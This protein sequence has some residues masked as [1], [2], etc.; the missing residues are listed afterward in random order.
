MKKLILTLA[1]ACATTL[2]VARTITVT[3]TEDTFPVAAPGSLRE[4]LALATD[5]DTITFDDSLKGQTINIVGVNTAKAD[6]SLVIDKAITID[7]NGVIIDGGWNGVAKSDAGGRIF[8]VSS[9]LGKV[10]FKDITLQN[11]HGR[12]WNCAGNQYFDGGAVYALSPVRFENCSLIHNASADETAYAPSG[13]GARGGGAISA[14]NDVEIVSC[15]FGTN[16]IPTGSSSYGG[17]IR[18]V[19]GT[20][21]VTDTVF[22]HDYSSTFGGGVAYI[23][24][25]VTGATFRNCK[26]IEN[27]STMQNGVAGGAIYAEMASNAA[28][29]LFDCVF[30]GGSG[31]NQ[32]GAICCRNNVAL[33][34]VN[35]EFADSYT[36]FGGAIYANTTK[37]L[38][39]LN[40]TFLGNAAATW[41][42][43][44]EITDRA[45]CLV[46]CTIAGSYCAG[47]NGGGL[48]ASRGLHLLNT[49]F[50]YNYWG[51]SMDFNDG[52]QN[53]NTCLRSLYK[54]KST[55]PFG[56]N[57]TLATSL[58][59]VPSVTKL[60]ANYQ[61]VSDMHGAGATGAR[62]Q[63]P[64]SV[65]MPMFA[66]DPKSVYSSR[67]IAI[68]KDSVLNGTGYPVR[69]NADYSYVEY[70][71]DEGATWKQ[72]FKLED[73]V[74][75]ANMTL[76]AADQRGVPYK[77]GIPPI[78][79]ATVAETSASGLQ[80]FIR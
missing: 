66:E 63:L 53:E 72:F 39:F 18:Q 36:S 6:T 25:E 29:K 57:Y 42:G 22:D 2:V 78:G 24:A 1:V 33:V 48:Y 70:S 77:N 68:E 40:C 74:D 13:V 62:V 20:L 12:G 71:E 51:S 26:F 9:G 32:G 27:S 4:A 35:C 11:G 7:G 58:D 37:P 60:F 45:L 14:E 61:M 17:A 38:L 28:L 75:T 5:G 3:S 15:F 43:A 54:G 52:N 67:V 69:A 65:V 23:G 19:R 50:G 16:C 59:E 8:I 30:R 79:A 41:G 31:A 73:G 46:N 21:T 56:S 44:M 49:V 47:N 34:A 80:I 64:K 10:A 55:A 76:I